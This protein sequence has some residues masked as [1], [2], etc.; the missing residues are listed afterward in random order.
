[1]DPRPAPHDPAGRRPQRRRRWPLPWRPFGLLAAVAVVGL[2]L[3]G[4]AAA[5]PAVA[6]RLDPGED[7][8][9]VRTDDGPVRDLLAGD[10]RTY[11]SSP[12]SPAQRRLSDEMVG[13]WTRFAHT[14]N[15][16]GEGI[17]TWPRFRGGRGHVQSLAPGSGGIRPV[18]LG[19]EH[20]CGFWQSLGA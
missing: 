2:A 7:P 14:G 17:T 13:A 12:L 8:A 6:G 11:A 16:N 4:L 10:H 9:V 5:G 19:R 18:D 20:R 15:P 3:S 1:M